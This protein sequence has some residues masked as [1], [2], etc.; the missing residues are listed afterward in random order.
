FWDALWLQPQRWEDEMIQ[1][2]RHGARMLFKHKTFT[3]VAVLTLAIGVGLST[4]IFTMTY[5]ILLRALPYPEPERLVTISLTNTIAAAAGISR[6]SVNSGNW[7]EGRGQTKMFG[8]IWRT[9]GG[10]YL[11]L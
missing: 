2:L 9:R 1:D 6:F 5:N 7:L 4:A 3:A 8:E 11:Q 10:G